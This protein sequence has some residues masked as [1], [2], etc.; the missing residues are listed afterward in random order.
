[1]TVALL[2]TGVDTGHRFLGR[3]VLDGV[4]V[5]D[6]DESAQAEPHPETRRARAARRPSSPASSRAR[7]ARAA[8][9][10]SPRAPRSFPIRVAGWQ[11]DA[12][13]AF[14]VYSRTDQLVAGLE[15]AVDPND[16][17]DTHDA[18]RIALLGVAEPFG[19]FDDSPAAQAV[20]GA[21]RHDTLVVAPAGNDGPAGVRFGSISGPGGS[22][23]ALTVG[24]ADLRPRLQD[25]RVVLRT[26]LRAMLDRRLP[27]AGAV[28]PREALELEL[29][30]PD[31]PGDPA[32]ARA[33]GA[34]AGRLLRQPRVQPRRRP[35]RARARRRVAP[36][37]C[38]GGRPR[39]RRGGRPLR[40]ASCRPVRSA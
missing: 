37:R 2:D 6:G 15:R 1:M 5:V 24:A 35:G 23:A 34:G 9:R 20:A 8:S 39:R 13:G 36:G 12:R 27:L 7:A 14:S 19:A 28:G 17:G 11:R 4:D 30:Q 10:G 33:A 21:L 29:A 31:L 3:R 32:R 16:D 26:G 25:V 22:R 38:R 40:Q 18:A